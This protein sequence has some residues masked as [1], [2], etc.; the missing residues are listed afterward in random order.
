MLGRRLLSRLRWLHREGKGRTGRRATALACGG[1]ISP[2]IKLRRHVDDQRGDLMEDVTT[3]VEVCRT[4]W[5]NGSVWCWVDWQLL[6]GRSSRKVI[7]QVTLTRLWRVWN[8]RLVDR[9]Q[10]E[11]DRWWINCRKLLLLFLTNGLAGVDAGGRPPALAT[12]HPFMMSVRT[13]GV[14]LFTLMYR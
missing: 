1:A 8:P 12:L 5:S 10:R 11:L 14:T 3:I 7:V 4:R 13:S 2:R 9:A 6:R